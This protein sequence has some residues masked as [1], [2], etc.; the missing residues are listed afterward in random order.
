MSFDANMA[1]LRVESLSKVFRRYSSEWHRIGAI[2]G[3]GIK[4]VEVH[5]VLQ[6]INFAISRGE[7]IG[8]VG[9]NGAGKST[10]LKIITG[11]LNPSE[12]FVQIAGRVSAILE[13][14]MGFHPDLSGR[15]NVYHSAGLMGFTPDQI[16]EKIDEIES[17]AEIGEYFDEPVRVYSSGMQMRVAFAVATAW[18]PDIL[19]VDEALS[20]GDS[21]FQHKSFKR[22]REFR[23]MGTSLLIVSH[24]K[25]AIQAVCDRAILLEKGQILKDGAPEEV[26]D[27]YNALIAVKEE[28]EEEGIA[29]EQIRTEDGRIAT[30]SGD[31]RVKLRKIALY[32]RKEEEIE[33]VS[34]GE[35]V[36]LKIV[37]ELVEEVDEL[38]LGYMIKDRVGQAVFGTNT[39]FMERVLLRPEVGRVLEYRFSFDMN[40]GPGSYS[41]NTSAHAGSSHVAGNYFWLDNALIFEVVNVDKNGFIGVAW[42][43]P[44][45]EIEDVG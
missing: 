25:A 8:I 28:E 10:L 2:A 44:E 22:I 45:L 26:L 20:V 43:P 42:L 7:A 24:D 13:L 23:E 5:R 35:R 40:L 17:F 38:V 41:F 29:I 37:I 15:Q 21:Y 31:M 14:G 34:V 6:G 16:A 11:T 9:R 4:P 32:N 19:I 12:G 3:L 36:T 27:Y 39:F 30:L 1:V 33:I 18:R